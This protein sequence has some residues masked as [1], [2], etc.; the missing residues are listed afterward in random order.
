MERHSKKGAF[1]FGILILG[2]EVY[3]LLKK[4]FVYLKDYKKEALLSPFFKMI[5]AI[6]EL[7]VPLV[8]A[9]M[10]DRGIGQSDV[11]FSVKM[12]LILVLLAAIGLT[13][14]LT[15]QYFAAKAAICFTASLRRALFSHIQ[16]FS[17]TELDRVGA[18]TLITRIT[19]DLNQLQNGVNMT[20]RLFLRSPFI[21]FG[22]MIMAYSID[23]KSAMIFLITIILLSIVVFGI[24][25]ICIPL[26]EKIQNN[27]DNVLSITREN[28][29]GTRVI[30]AFCNEAD[31]TS[32]FIEKN[33]I[34]TSMQNFTGRISALMNP[35]TLFIV[36]AAILF[37]IYTGAVEV[38][39]G[40]LTTG[41]VVAL[42]NYMS[43]ILVELIKLAN[44]IISITKA[45]ACGDRV[46]AILEMQ[47]S[48]TAPNEEVTIS[49]SD[50][51]IEMKNVSLR[52]KGAGKP[53]LTELNF[54]VNKGETVGIIGGTGSGKTSLVDLIARL[55]DAESGTVNLFGTDI[56][57][58]PLSQ[59]RSFYGI[60][61]QKTTLFK[62]TIRDNIK[63]GYPNATD[64]EI[65]AA[66]KTAQ[67]FDFVMQKEGTLDFIL[68]QGGKNLSG[69]QRQRLAIARAIVKK[70][71]ILI[72]DDS[73]SALDFA[74]DARLRQELRGTS[75]GRTT[76]IVSQRASTVRFADKIIVLDDGIAVGIGTHDE[77]INSCNVYK[78]IYDSQFRKE[79]VS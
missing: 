39:D 6:F 64:D 70:P 77:L 60:V 69:G 31:E 76:F 59:L 67:A 2:Q 4:L 51:A 49:D 14:S 74:T 73:S 62:G 42:Y 16:T 32:D 45:A 41:E 46:Q 27:L 57:N 47:T 35:F 52:Y 63:W 20:L 33:N 78:E 36:N 28:L 71:K 34:L 68:E 26:Y 10:I 25:L 9:A 55:Y 29:T 23:K 22:A 24:M 19:S 43:Q 38:N 11:S 54:I 5:E 65:I 53:S 7:F 15:A 58:Y 79:A 12:G 48:I 50:I 30:R 17:Y 40:I 21:V 56:K 72:L 37:L 1:Q 44:L 8:V 66:L 75:N 13:S 3:F 61:P 18:S